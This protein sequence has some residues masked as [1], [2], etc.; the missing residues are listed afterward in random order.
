M[1]SG[2]SSQK[3]GLAFANNVHLDILKSS[4]GEGPANI[5][6]AYLEGQ[7][8]TGN[9]ERT[10]NEADVLLVLDDG[11][12]PAH[13]AILSGSSPFFNSIFEMQG[14]ILSPIREILMP[15]FPLR[16]MR[17]VIGLLYNDHVY[18]K[19]EKEAEEVRNLL[20]CLG[21][22][23]HSKLH[24]SKLAKYCTRA[25]IDEVKVLPKSTK[26]EIFG[27]AVVL[28]SVEGPSGEE[29][30]S[31]I[32]GPKSP[33]RSVTT[34]VKSPKCLL[35]SPNF[36]RRT[37]KSST[38]LPVRVQRGKVFE[39]EDT[40]ASESE[41]VAESDSDYSDSDI[42]CDDS[43]SQSMKNNSLKVDTA[44]L[45]KGNTV[46]TKPVSILVENLM[47]GILTKINRRISE[48][49]KRL[50][51]PN[52]PIKLEKSLDDSD[53][54]TDYDA[55]EDRFKNREWFLSEAKRCQK[56][57]MDHETPAVA[58]GCLTGHSRLRC[59]FCFRVPCQNIAN[60]EYPRLLILVRWEGWALQ[61][62][63]IAPEVRRLNISEES[64][65][66]DNLKADRDH[67][68]FTW[69]V[70]SFRSFLT[71]FNNFNSWVF[72]IE[73]IKMS[74]SENST[75]GRTSA[76]VSNK[77]LGK[78]STIRTRSRQQ[79]TKWKVDEMKAAS[80]ALQKKAIAQLGQVMRATPTRGAI[81]YALGKDLF[82]VLRYLPAGVMSRINNFF[83]TQ[84][85]NLS[86]DPSGSGNSL[87]QPDSGPPTSSSSSSGSPNVLGDLYNKASSYAAASA[88]FTTAS[89]KDK[90][91]N[92]NLSS[93]G[94]SPDLPDKPKTEKDL[95]QKSPPQRTVTTPKKKVV[96]K[97]QES[98]GLEWAMDPDLKPFLQDMATEWKN[99]QARTRYLVSKLV[100]VVDEENKSKMQYL[101]DLYRHVDQYRES[102]T[103]A[104]ECGAVKNL[105]K[106]VR[107]E[108]NDACLMNCARETLAVLGCNPPVKGQGI[109]VLSIDGGGVRGL[110]AIEVLRMI[111][112]RTGKKVHELFDYICG[113]ST[114]SILAFL[115]G[116]H[117]RTLGECESL[118]KQLSQEIFNQNT[119]IGA[120]NLFWS[121]SYYNTA[122]WEKILRKHIGETPLITLARDPDLPRV[123]AISTV[124]NQE[125]VY[126][127]VFRT[128]A[129]KPS[130]RSRYTG[131]SRYEMWEAVRASAA[132]P[133]YFE[134]IRLGNNL[135]QDGGVLVNNP[136]SVALSEA[137]SL[138]EGQPLQCVMSLGTGQTFSSRK[139]PN[140]SDL[141]PPDTANPKSPSSLSWKDSI[142]ISAK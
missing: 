142:H 12:I 6:E 112:Q 92:R 51:I 96:E 31:S 123:A 82:L 25:V 80:N 70:K 139:N 29:V 137:K 87:M 69:T 131:G 59:Y 28:S 89:I 84:Q 101:E 128:Y 20:S 46:A 53:T 33:L 26:V 95:S 113:V 130:I 47:P 111:E 117:R 48:G 37:P 140:L 16:I 17:K 60:D 1:R 8:Q 19:S 11:V 88:S 18:L 62:F 103:T 44:K 105:L 81:A 54:S 14:F 134:E 107:N 68:K 35:K 5:I 40:S 72:N 94:S 22:N 83:P 41:S 119:F 4:G 52:V 118:Y 141:I 114:G 66:C 110:V 104:I 132:A 9:K 108:S 116:A 100:S 91:W 45:A 3:A 93:T 57:K 136:T 63:T 56:C 75:P 97:S 126:P 49:N 71:K 61:S 77:E 74:N 2:S 42:F 135:H 86:T 23:L 79:L 30:S 50:A 138:W 36:A 127:Y 65:H 129:F 21:I 64:K 121:H 98:D 125:R 122:A 34:L 78:S 133:T 38:V 10:G 99:V 90:V 15:E 39:L 109:K 7:R 73:H 115:I 43:K 32:K 76:T 24:S 106:I 55:D 102:R 124:V 85:V 120:G 13:A 58:S 67:L 27:Q